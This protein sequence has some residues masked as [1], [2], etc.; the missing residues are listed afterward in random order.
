M[1]HYQLKNILI[2]L[3]PYLKDIINDIKKSD[4]CKIQLMTAI[5]FISF[6]DN[7]QGRAIHPK[8][9]NIEIMINDK[10]DEVIEKLFQSFLYRYQIGRE[11]SMKRW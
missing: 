10:A 2:K 5:H 1:K 7:D 3:E 11:T 4:T 8:S 9:D 6:K